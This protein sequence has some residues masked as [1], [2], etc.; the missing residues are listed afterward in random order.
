[1]FFWLSRS[2]QKCTH[3]ITWTPLFYLNSYLQNT[4]QTKIRCVISIYIPQKGYVNNH[5]YYFSIS[6][7][8][9]HRHALVKYG[10]AKTLLIQLFWDCCQFIVLSFWL[11][12]IK[13]NVVNKRHSNQPNNPLFTGLEIMELQNKING[14]VHEICLVEMFSNDTRVVIGLY[15]NIFWKKKLNSNVA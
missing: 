11:I 4:S 10:H 6:L 5:F 12:I 14:N 13:R 7:E 9:Y 3:I 1:M 2:R 8:S 15:R